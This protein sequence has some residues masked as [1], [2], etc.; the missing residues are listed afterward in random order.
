MVRKTARIFVVVQLII[1]SQ[2]TFLTT[3]SHAAKAP[4]IRIDL[5]RAA[6]EKSF[7]VQKIEV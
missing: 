5:R 6:D 3:H 7:V 1:N 4:T 2:N